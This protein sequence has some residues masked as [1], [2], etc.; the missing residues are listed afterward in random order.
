MVWKP[1]SLILGVEKE[2]DRM[3][4]SKTPFLWSCVKVGSSGAGTGSVEGKTWKGTE[5]T[6]SR[7]GVPFEFVAAEKR[8]IDIVYVIRNC[9]HSYDGGLWRKGGVRRETYEPDRPGSLTIGPN[10]APS[11]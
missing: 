2:N 6:L 7:R 1:V 8:A 5:K 11:C 4:D 3:S 9:A 10:W